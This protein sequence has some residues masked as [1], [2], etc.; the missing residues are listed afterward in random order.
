MPL[1]L[2]EKELND[3]D[4]QLRR[5]GQAHTIEGWGTWCGLSDTQGR[6]IANRN[7]LSDGCVS[8]Q[9]RNRFAATDR[10]QVLAQPGLEI[11]DSHLL[12]DHSMTRNG[13]NSKSNERMESDDRFGYGGA[14][15]DRPSGTDF[16][17]SLS[18]LAST[19]YFT[20]CR[21]TWT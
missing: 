9:D 13:H 2:L 21:S 7:D 4:V 18:T 15:D 10:P 14:I 8:I 11:S 1:T 12:H 3:V 5:L 20:R 6:S 19:R 16:V 17:G